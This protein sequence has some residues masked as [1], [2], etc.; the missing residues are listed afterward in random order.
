MTMPWPAPREKNCVYKKY[1]FIEMKEKIE[2]SSIALSTLHLDDWS[3][4]TCA[5]TIS[6]GA[7]NSGIHHPLIISTE[8][9]IFRF[10]SACNLSCHDFRIFTTSFG[11]P[12]LPV[13]QYHSVVENAKMLIDKWW[14]ITGGYDISPS[15]AY[16]YSIFCT[17]LPTEIDMIVLCDVWF[18]IILSARLL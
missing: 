5:E 10:W 3:T 1:D 4:N 2:M 7:A 9:G 8:V 13:N 6:F 17:N 15:R 18:W 16:I 11:L 14:L 12:I